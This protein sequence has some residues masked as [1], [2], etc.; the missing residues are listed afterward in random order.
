MAAPLRAAVVGTGFVGAQHVDALRRIGAAVEVVVASEP[1]RARAAAALLGVDR[2]TAD[3]AAAVADPA[4]DV[5][6]VCVPNDLHVDI[7]LAALAAGKHLVCEKPL[8]ADLAGAR[9]LAAAAARTDRTAVLCHNYRFY[10]MVAE[11]RLQVRGGALGPLHAVRGVY[12]Q[13]WMLAAGATNWRVDPARGGASRTV[14]DIGT[15]WIDL[16]ETVSGR[17]LEAVIAQ[18]GIVHERRPAS[19]HDGSFSAPRDEVADWVQVTTEDQAGMLLRFEGGLQGTL[20]VS[21]VAAGH[22]NDLQVSVDGGDGSATWRQERPDRLE[23]AAGH[24]RRVLRR[25]PGA[26]T[27]G[28]NALARLPAGHNEGWGDAMRNLLE[29][30]YAEI[31]G[32]RGRL[33]AEAAPLP[34]FDDGVRHLAFVEAALRSSA[35]ERWVTIEEM[36][37]PTRRTEEA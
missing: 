1:E 26:L 20:V 35:D 23:L 37:G 2:A 31:A 19:A 36:L 3:W 15:H 5:V 28:A 33:E 32:T 24:D 22:A 21:Q 27:G 11:L 6:H 18:L 10:P 14:A 4:V 9:A 34:T 16:A 17:R 30:A 12:L 13:D 29:A 25:T 8:A 7:G